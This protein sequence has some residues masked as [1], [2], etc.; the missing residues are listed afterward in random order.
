MNPATATPQRDH[1]VLHLPKQTSHG[2]HLALSVLGLLF[3][4]IPALF[5]GFLLAPLG[6]AY[7]T[8]SVVVMV[9]VGLLFTFGWPVVWLLVHDRNTQRAARAR[10]GC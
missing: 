1:L 2:L 10:Y 7:P 4:W 3:G 8:V 5:V 6:T 9:S